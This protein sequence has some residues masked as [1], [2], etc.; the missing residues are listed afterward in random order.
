[1]RDNM[2]CGEEYAKI[3]NKNVYIPYQLSGKC[4]V[5]TVDEDGMMVLRIYPADS[6]PDEVEIKEPNIIADEET[7]I[8]NH[9]LSVPYRFLDYMGKDTEVAICGV[10]EYIEIFKLLDYERYIQEAD[11][12]NDIQRV[13]NEVLDSSIQEVN[14]EK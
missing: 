11:S 9:M 7:I 6:S 3:C 10:C 14:N 8:A 5:F 1:M 13:L 12:E 4:R 2:F